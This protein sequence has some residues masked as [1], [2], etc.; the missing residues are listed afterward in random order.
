MAK[1]TKAI[2]AVLPGEIYPTTLEAGTEVEG[3]VAEIA[4]A[5]GALGKSTKAVKKAPENK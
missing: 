4:E 3:R 2:K 5:M 1:L